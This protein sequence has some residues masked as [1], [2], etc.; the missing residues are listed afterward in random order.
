MIAAALLSNKIKKLGKKDF[1]YLLAFLA[2]VTTVAFSFA[3]DFLSLA[4]LHGLMGFFV[5]SC[6]I[7]LGSRVLEI[8]DNT[9][10]GRTRIYIESLVSLSAMIMNFSPSVISFA[11]TASYFLMWGIFISISTFLLWLWK[12]WYSP[13]IRWAQK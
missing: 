10:V 7:I 1:E 6:R 9:N 4:V 3:S 11:A 12:R 13:E 2:G 8:C 5:W